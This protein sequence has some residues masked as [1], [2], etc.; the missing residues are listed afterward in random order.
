MNAL[1]D[2]LPALLI[3]VPLLGAFLTP[4]FGRF[5]PKL[6]KPWV[7]LAVFA[8]AAVAVAT[9][10]K[11]FISGPI[12]YAFG[13]PAGASAVSD[14]AGIPI[15]I[16]FT[17]DAFGAFMLLSAAIVSVSAALYLIASQKTRSGKPEFFALFLLLTTGIFGMVSTGD[18]FNFFVFL[19]INSLSAAAMVAYH[20][21]GGIA[22][23]G[24]IK[25]AIV[26]TLGG[27]MVLLG[28]GLLYSQY[29]SLN[30][31]VIASQIAPNTLTITALVLFI[32]AL[33]MKAGSVPFHFA[34]PD[35]YSVAPSGVTALMIVASQAGLYGIFRICFTVY[36]G[37]FN[38][39]T[40][41][42][43]IIILGLLSM[44]IGVT[45]ALPQK[46]VKRLLA[47]HAVSQTGYML[48]GVGV[49]VAV[50]GDAAALDAFGKTAMEGG[51]FH[52]FN[53]AMYK[54]LLFLA[55]GAVILRTGVWS[56]NKMG[57]LGH[58]MKWT[59]IFFLIGAFAIA[60][61]PPFN[62]FASKLMIYES[63]F[64]FSPV[65]SIIAMVVSI[66]TLASFMK[67]FHSLFL[68]PKQEEYAEVKEAPKVMIAAMVI[69]TVFVVG[70]GLFP[71][72]F[73]ETVI[74]PAADA[75]INTG[76]YISAVFGG[77]A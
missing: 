67:V 31:A 42:W 37:V 40:V 58:N 75:L 35:A 70:L 57:G 30:M 39:L 64:A 16:L 53:H 29:G 62:G 3:A 34:T 23:E 46:D 10:V 1:L 26:N 21:K 17:I 52:I 59:M 55:V 47:Y 32:T 44:V 50:L 63:V 71:D 74:S 48:L 8:S 76:S 24:A 19:E 11:V 77:G 4:L 49:C 27:L 54:G 33:A 25:Y 20:R 51:I 41:G 13:L 12:V 60:G 7:I 69:L 15:R 38:T 61:I 5:L 56:L 18:L 9:A 65:L 66:L 14:S 2:N 36:N 72:F 45:M 68:G 73:L 43:V 28:I 22:V 6:M